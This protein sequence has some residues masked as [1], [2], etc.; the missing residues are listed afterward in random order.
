MAAMLP[1]TPRLRIL[2]L[3]ALCVLCMPILAVVMVGQSLIGS[4][5]R[6]LRMAVALDQCGNAGLGGSEDETISS[7]AG[8]AA[9]D[10]EPWAPLAV[11]LIDGIFGAG[12]CR[13][14]MGE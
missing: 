2:L 12:H 11:A 8:R 9:R 10:G 6:A 13:A 4:I 7:R 3:C 1:R 5:D 14:S